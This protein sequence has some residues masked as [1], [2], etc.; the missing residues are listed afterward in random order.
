[1]CSTSV[2]AQDKIVKKDG[3]N[4]AC[5]VVELK[6]SFVIYKKWTE[7]NG[8]D[9]M[10]SRSD[11]SAIHYADGKTV[12]LSEV[13]SMYKPGNQNDGTQQY[14]DRALL[15][16]DAASQK[17][18]SGKL[19]TISWIGGAILATGGVITFLAGG[20]VSENNIVGAGLGIGAVAWT[21]T[22]LLLSNHE[23]KK[24]S[25]FDSLSIYQHDFN[26]PNGFSLSVGLDMINDHLVGEKTLGL[27]M[28]Y[29]F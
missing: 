24:A 9:Y 27:G 28:R 11:I 12:N 16:L 19:K 17:N 13:N 3:A 21:T 4:I 6:D 7:L 29:N 20:G 26:L 10:M 22:F 5:R 1:M 25:R 8:D 14:N 2:F 15:A 18:S 23:K